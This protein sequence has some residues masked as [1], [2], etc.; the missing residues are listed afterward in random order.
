[1]TWN[2]FKR[3]WTLLTEKIKQCWDQ[4]TGNADLIFSA[5]PARVAKWP[6]RRAP[7]P[8]AARSP[9]DPNFFQLD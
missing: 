7:R 9:L 3:L 1:M 4:L 2:S 8:N 6:G 5:V